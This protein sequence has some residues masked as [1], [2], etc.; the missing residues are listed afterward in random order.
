M[1]AASG[2]KADS[3]VSKRKKVYLILTAAILALLSVTAFV[4]LRN[5]SEAKAREYTQRARES[6]SNAD[7]ETA[8]LY[9]RRAMD[10]GEGEDAELLM[11]MADCYEAMGNY[12]KALET[13]RK[14]NTADPAIASRI[15][16]I[17]Q[18]RGSLINEGKV[19][20]VG[21]DFDRN[22]KSAMLDGKGITDAQ[23][24]EVA[25]LYALDSLSLRNNKLTSID[26]LS[27][28]GGLDE[29]D[30]SG[31][32]IRNVDALKNVRGLRVLNL[33]GNPISD[34]S[35]LRILTN[36]NSLNLTDTE[37]SEESV[38]VLAEALPH[39]AIRVT[40]DES[41]EILY[42]N[43]RFRADTK[44]LQLSEM[45]LR[46]I[47]ALEEFSEVRIL[48]LSNN[49]IGDI[50]PLMHLAKLE[51][52]NLAGNEVS[53]LRPL[54][55]LPNL[56]K[57]DVSNNLVVETVPLGVITS[58][59]ELNL[60]GNRLSSFS[61]LEKLRR[62]SDLNLSGTGLKDAV[63][64]EFYDMHSLTRLNLQ[65]NSGLSDKAVSA[66]KTEL[67]GCSILT[68]DL[69]YEV[70]FAGHTVRSDEKHLAFPA[71]GITDLNGLDR[72][73]RLEELDLS[74][75]EI[76]NLYAFEVCASKESLKVLDLSDNRISDVTS[77]SA[78]SALEELDLSDNQIE[79]TIGLERLTSL[80]QLNLSGN[81]VLEAQLKL[82][83]DA[84]P[85]CQIIVGNQD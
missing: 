85:N 52:L 53:D 27:T 77:L 42:G 29:L 19:T 28:L 68:S 55:G 18:K 82:L 14:L 32:Q 50:R 40:A 57:L 23:L 81:P 15:Q 62:I 76:S 65:D 58:L 36:L 72:L 5:S 34:C 3:R 84:I 47:G 38:A 44:E 45:G 83:H 66:L 46:E 60:S 71:S 1:K 8:L 16:S 30:L 67:N 49:E 59:E 51:S 78:L 37:V 63:L 2:Y 73:N 24:H 10:E 70:D 20:V 54:M 35:C 64:S 9:L 6:Y 11:L 80:K 56:T 13:L 21:L 12:P 43:S 7:Y 61:G 41:E 74:R 69:V 75:N 31:N 48:N 26:E 79:V 17:E 33:S 25:S 22:A 39:C 4:L